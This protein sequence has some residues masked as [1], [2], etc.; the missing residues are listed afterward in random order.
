MSGLRSLVQ[1]SKDTALAFA[2][3]SL[4]NTRLGAFG[5]ITELSLDTSR[6]SAQL[7]CIL[8]GEVEPIDLDVRNYKIEHVDGDNWLTVVDAVASREWLTAALQ[9]FVL[10]RRFH[11]SA[12]AGAALRLLA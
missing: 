10:G 7:R 3:R 4:L 6:R 2:V 12:K 11:V 9:Q 1:G 8:H 5:E